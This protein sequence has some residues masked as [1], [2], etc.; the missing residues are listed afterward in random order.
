MIFFKI[1]MP[2]N[3]EPTYAYVQ[4][5]EITPPFDNSNNLINNPKYASLQS[6]SHSQFKKPNKI[7]FMLIIGSINKLVQMQ[8]KT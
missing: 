5:H 7:N 6:L 3:G 8:G 2:L 1:Q 4:C